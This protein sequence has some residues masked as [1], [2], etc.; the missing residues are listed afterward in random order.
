[1]DDFL[2]RATLAA[3]AVALI[4]GPLG[5]VVVWRRMAYVGDT[6]AHGALLGVALGFLFDVAPILGVLVTTLVLA[7]LL[8]L[9][10]GS[11]RIAGDTVLG[12]LAH[13]ALALGLVAVGLTQGVRVDLLGYL[14]GDV[15]AVTRDDLI[16]LWGGGAI[17]L[18]VLAWIWRD[19]LAL[20]VDPDLAAAE[21]VAVPRTRLLFILLVAAAV[22]LA[23]KVV[24]VLLV[25]AL[26]IIPAATAG[27]LS[28]TPE[29]AAG[30][31]AALGAVAA[32]AGLQASLAVD[33]PAGPSIVVAALFAFVLSLSLRTRT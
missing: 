6:L 18:A 17:I 30:M 10:Q 2:I 24:G 14:F 4:A 33:S 13:G 8:V 32:V 9:L 25:T 11:G 27:R 15:L 1:M 23:M 31:A 7:V 3:V 19:L 28:R 16:L 12:I 20:T 26:L 5:C 29:R 21:G 22:A